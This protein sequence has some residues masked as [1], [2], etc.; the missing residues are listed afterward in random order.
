MPN[1]IRSKYPGGYYFFTQIT[2][3]RIPI[4]LNPVFFDTLQNVIR[5]V[6]TKYP[7]QILAYCFLPDH[8]HFIWKLPDGDSNYSH[9]WQMIKGLS[10]IRFN[11][12]E[13]SQGKQHWQGRFWEHIIRN[14]EDYQKH[15]HYVH[16]NPIKHGYVRNLSEWNYSSFRDYVKKGIYDIDFGLSENVVD[17][18][19]NFGE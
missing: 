5:E 10:T 17:T 2:Y 9:R 15:F 7:F 18:H 16:I 12:L 14:E 3:Q 6:K 13:G 8:M 11:K 4:L 1:Y 19:D